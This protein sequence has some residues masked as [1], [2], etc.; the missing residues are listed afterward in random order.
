METMSGMPG[1]RRRTG[2]RLAAWLTRAMVALPC[3]DLLK[4]LSTVA[5]RWFA[6]YEGVNRRARGRWYATCRIQEPHC[7]NSVFVWAPK[8]HAC[9]RKRPLPRCCGHRELPCCGGVRQWA[10]GIVVPV[11]DVL[12]RIT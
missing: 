8:L 6:V 10:A 5:P 7:T 4:V 2:S 9:E 11:R 12:N 1:F 3:M